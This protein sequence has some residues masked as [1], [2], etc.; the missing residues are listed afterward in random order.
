MS[1]SE[2]RSRISELL[3]RDE[4]RLRRRLDGTRRIRDDAARS[5]ALD[6]IAEEVD[7]ARLRLETRLAAVP[8]ITYPEALPV[9]AR[10]DDIAAAIRDHQVVV[11]AGETGSGKTTQIPKICLEL[12]R[13]VRGQIGHTQPRR[14]AA[15]TVAERIAEE[16]DR[17][18]GSTVGYKVRFTDHVGEDT[19]VKVMTDGILLAEIQTDRMLRRYDTLIIDEA[20]ERSLNIDF[21]LGYLRDLLPK[22]PD[23]K[24]VITSATIE[25]QR[26]AEHFADAAGKPAPVIEVS[27]RTYPV[28]VRYRPLVTTTLLDDEEDDDTVREEPID[29]IEGIA[30]AVDELPA[31]GDILVFM[32]GEREIR[33][34]ADALV[35]KDLRNTEV[36]P[37]YGR[38]SAAEQHKVFERHAG[39]RI[40]LATNVAETSL[41]VPGIRYVIDPGTARISRYSHRLKVQ[42]LPIEPVSQASANQRKG[43]C[44]RTSDGICIRLYSEEDFDGRPEFTEPEILRTNLASVILQMTNLGLGDLPKFPFIDPPDRRNITDG[45]KLLEE[46][47]ALDQGK[48]T[49]LGRQLAQLPVDPRLA[50][51]VIE[52]DKQDCLAE[53]MVIAAALSIQDPRERPADK[54]QQADE[55]HA[56][57][58]DKESDFFTYLNLW[59]YLREKQHELSGNQFRRLC[60]S[61]FLNYL[62]VREWQDIYTQLKQVVRTLKLT[63]KEDWEAGVAPQPVHTALLA[64][65]LSH[66]GLK[67]T[68]KREYLGARGAK[69]AIFPGSALF[70]RQ[71]RW[72]MSAELVETSRLWARVN[73][74]IEPEW[75]EK[76]AP[77]L[78]KRS[79]S[80]P[81]WDRKLGAV[82]AFEKV[83]LYGLPIVPRRRVG[84]SK[85]DPEVSREL[86]IRH[87]LVEGDWETHHKFFEA[88][89]R[90]LRQITDLENRARRRDIA[91]DDETVFSLYDAKIP[92]EVVS[93]RHF[94]GWWKHERR[95][96]PDLLT[97][98]RDELV[99]AGRDSV[100]PNAFPDA[101]LAAG[102]K[103]PL[104][105]EFEPGKHADG[106]TVQ[107]PLDLIN[108]VDAEDFGWSVPGFRKDVVIALIR[109]LPKAM[110]TS[111]VPVPDWAE[112]VLDRVPARRGPL[113]DAIGNELRRL[114][115]TIVPRDAWRPDQVPDHLRMNFRI[116]NEAGEVVA[117]GRDLEV[118]RRELQ[119]K[120]QATISRAAGD[121]ERTGITTNDFGAIPHR[122]A[123][124]RGGYQ[125]NV[126]PALVDEGASV[127][128]K[129]FETEA[130]QRIAMRAGTRR[131]LLL[132]LP[133]A[134]RFLQGRLD[135]RAKLELSRAN[136]YRSVAELL[137]DCAGAAVD[138]LVAD[139]GGPVWSS[140]EFASLRD[141]V[142][143]DLVDA[144]ANVVTQVQA[145]LATAYDVDQRVRQFK[146]PMLLPALTDIRQQLKGLIYPGFVTETGW[147]QLHHMPR[148]LRGISYRLDRLGG[149]AGRDRQLITQIQ[150][151]EAEYRELTAEA[152]PD[153]PAAD[154]LREIRW[155]IEELRINFFAQTLGTAYP[156]SDKR[157]FKAMDALPL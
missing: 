3:P 125:V 9:S 157:I 17:P 24:L 111:F 81:H 99:N 135:N 74:R 143:E 58:V 132:T 34:T 113:P 147:K 98:T 155:M 28:E 23:L 4:H 51:M 75:A 1:V 108:K 110:R 67:D 101:W 16:L 69:F 133:P 25:T 85:V 95:T 142:R 102:V 29:Q 44:G 107:L 97:F 129:V 89:R 90:L 153:S 92:A 76:L 105:Y 64:G 94:D 120:V 123:Q 146:D 30:A 18:L 48:L 60:R 21:I 91:V 104:R 150:E 61:E 134:A 131:L 156:V 118:L 141:T 78:V 7:R 103:L 55:K 144:V 152:P 57:F 22:R 40:V 41:T 114:T 148:Y 112:A 47:G 139:A 19:L 6:E 13:G 27:G 96:N 54:Q 106:V 84:Y 26:F 52:A 62:R 32:S 86:F 121:L 119:P 15:R 70:K 12:G 59:R 128:V 100:D 43:R 126:W 127:G 36:V 72:V 83:T 149:S 56:R 137:D 49:P 66:I 63:L 82:M 79:Y 140:V 145:V 10:K 45:I 14:I 77:H 151:I 80:E 38:L 154:G 130:E 73:A 122:V 138:K 39:R 116:V 20:H 50:R 11:V 2:L 68:D 31:D 109:A 117:E 37:L 71:P 124:V 8:P 88:N 5:T 65:L 115:G 93:S 42:R 33:D 35:K 136:P 87:A 46:L 53:V